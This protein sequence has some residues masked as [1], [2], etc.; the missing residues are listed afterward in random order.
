MSTLD[1]KVYSNETIEELAEKLL[2]HA[3]YDNVC[4]VDIVQ[5]AS[6][7]GLKVY[8]KLLENSSGYIKFEDNGNNNIYVNELDSKSRRRFTIAHEIGHYLLHRNLIQRNNGT[9][10][11]GNN[12]INRDIIEIQ[13]N[14]C[15]AAL[16]MPRQMVM[17]YYQQ[18]SGSYF[19]KL[20]ALTSMF[21]VSIEAMDIRLSTLGLNK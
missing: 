13:A 19:E 1:V 3:G 20:L 16:L 2:S 7:L 12:G 8:S 10:Y 5:L 15:A 9:L 18:L 6:A 21:N 17:Q 11:R 4:S 14:R